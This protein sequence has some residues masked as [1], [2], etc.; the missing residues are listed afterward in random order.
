MLP[1]INI[2]YLIFHD[3][4]D[5]FT[6]YWPFLA[7]RSDAVELGTSRPIVTP[8]NYPYSAKGGQ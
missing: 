7:N 5:S 8:E 1:L 6:T 3:Y 2:Y 4:I